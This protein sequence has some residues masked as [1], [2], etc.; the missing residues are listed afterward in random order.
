M[1]TP[2][3]CGTLGPRC[4]CHPRC[5]DVATGVLM[6]RGNLTPEEA[7]GSLL[8]AARRKNVSM[9]VWAREVIDSAVKGNARPYG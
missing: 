7:R 9:H 5:I 2:D 4:Q 1:A 3:D 8:R 6:Q